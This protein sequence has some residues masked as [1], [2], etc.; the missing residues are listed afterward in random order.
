MAKLL[1]IEGK[2]FTAEVQAAVIDLLEEYLAL[3]KSGDIKSVA[4]AAINK[5]N[6]SSIGASKN[7]NSLAMLGAVSMLLYNIQQAYDEK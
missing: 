2:T 1:I 3:A 7:N 5:D 6:G 4:I